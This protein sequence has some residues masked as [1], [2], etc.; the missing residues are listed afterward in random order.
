MITSIGTNDPPAKTKARKW[1]TMLSFGTVWKLNPGFWSSWLAWRREQHREEW[2]SGGKGAQR[3][4]RQENVVREAGD[5]DLP[6]PPP[7]SPPRSGWT[8]KRLGSEFAHH[9]FEPSNFPFGRPTQSRRF[10]S[11]LAVAKDDDIYFFILRRCKVYLLRGHSWL[12][13][14]NF[15]DTFSFLFDWT[16]VYL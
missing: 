5:S 7:P 1:T 6:I 16:A 15:Q 13:S 9:D 14:F 11:W 12:L 10:V 8:G 4:R 2:K 3:Y